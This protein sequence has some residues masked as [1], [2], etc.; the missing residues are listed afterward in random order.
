VRVLAGDVG[1]SKTLIQVAD[2]AD[3]RWHVIANARYDNRDYSSFGALL[4]KFCASE[5]KSCSTIAA[6]GL[7]LAGPVNDDKVQLTNLPWLIDIELLQRR[8]ATQQV[9]LINDMQGAGYG[10]ASIER[11]DLLVLNAGEPV[12]HGVCG[13]IGAGTGLGEALMVWHDGRYE[14]HAGEGG[15]VDFAPRDEFELDLLVYLRAKLERVSYEH[16]LCGAGLVR[17]FEFMIEHSGGL[18]SPGLMGDLSH[19]DAAA[20]ICEYALNSKSAKAWSAL[21]RFIRIYGAQAGNL[22]LTLGAR[23]GIYVVGGIAPKICAAFRTAGFM[24]AFQANSTMSEFLARIPVT[25][26]L[27]PNVALFGARAVAQ[28]SCL[29]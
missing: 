24:T 16:L 6:V 21:E 20:V 1:G 29:N 8:F 3:N 10:I 13:L 11:S 27:D 7:A 15:H 12:T 25:V 2:Y 23:G 19:Q 9:R 22:A 14:V 17:I 18:V 26:V 4:E 5:S 28:R